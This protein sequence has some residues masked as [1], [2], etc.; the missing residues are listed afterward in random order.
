M[1]DPVPLFLR[2]HTHETEIADARVADEN[3]HIADCAEGIGHSLQRQLG[4]VV[5]LS[6]GNIAADC[7]SA[8]FFRHSLGGGVFFFVEEEN[9]VAFGGEQ[10]HGC[11]AD[12]PAP[13]GN[14]NG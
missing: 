13:T 14:H 6:V 12:A 1:K 9:S 8:G 4:G 2:H 5:F 11:R 3:I 10:L 7:G